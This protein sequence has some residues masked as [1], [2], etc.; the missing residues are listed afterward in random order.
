VK[1]VPVLIL[2]VVACM[3]GIAQG[4]L[5]GAHGRLQMQSQPGDWIGGGNT[6]DYIYTPG[7]SMAFG[8]SVSA[9]LSDGQPTRL[10][11]SFN[12]TTLWFGTDQLGIPIQTG[13]YLNAQRTPFAS[14]GHPGLEVD[15]QGRGSNTL[16]GNFT[17]SDLTYFPGT[18]TLDTF[19]ASFEQ[20]SDGAAPALF[21]TFSYAATPEP[22]TLTLLALGGA[23]ALARR[24]KAKS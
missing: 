21:G 4:A 8:S 9:T 14:A 11:F 1:T 19:T 15:M 6:Y 22:A 7:S 23:A 10:R 16:T 17:I 24:R 20:H 12:D 18:Y 2:M 5:P 3:A 13:T